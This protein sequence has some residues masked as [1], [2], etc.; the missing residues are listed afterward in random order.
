MSWVGYAIQGAGAANQA[1]SQQEQA[2]QSEEHADE[3]ALI[4]EQ[5]SRISRDI[6]EFNARQFEREA[7]SVKDVTDIEEER[8]SREARIKEGELVTGFGKSGVRGDVGSPINVLADE[9]EQFDIERAFTA[10][11][12]L[13]DEQKLGTQAGLER[14]QGRL[15]V[16]KG[17][18]QADITRRTGKD[19]A[20]AQN[21]A[22]TS[23]IL[24]TASSILAQRSANA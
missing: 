19:I 20:A 16:A 14:L 18:Q 15:T 8:I 22:A 5:E 11:Q 23:T 3:Q 4:L 2:A 9:A 10:R 12:G 7:E 21:L 13:I 1:L 24:N 17:I 6:N